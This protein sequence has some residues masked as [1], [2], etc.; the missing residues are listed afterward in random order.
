MLSITNSASDTMSSTLE[1][2]LGHVYLLRYTVL[3]ILQKEKEGKK[4]RKRKEKWRNKKLFF[5][6]SPKIEDRKQKL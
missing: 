4:H 6:K 5:R 2:N 3:H 1:L